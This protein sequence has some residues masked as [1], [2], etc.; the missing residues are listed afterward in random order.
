MIRWRG[1]VAVKPADIVK[2]APTQGV[3]NRS[4]YET[5]YIRRKT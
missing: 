1:Q 3:A 4:F 5:S 2:V